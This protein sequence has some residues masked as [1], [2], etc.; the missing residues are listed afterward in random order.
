MEGGRTFGIDAFLNFTPAQEG[1][2]WEKREEH[3]PS[4]LPLSAAPAHPSSLKIFSSSASSSSSLHSNL[5][6][7]TVCPARPLLLD[8]NML[9]A[10]ISVGQRVV[11]LEKET[12]EPPRGKREKAG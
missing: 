9:D 7:T 6:H 1:E 11:A 3:H 2:A 5:L 12:S 4:I 8:A 10:N